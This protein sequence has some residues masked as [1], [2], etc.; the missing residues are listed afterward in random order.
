MKAFNQAKILKNFFKYYLKQ[1]KFQ[2]I[3]HEKWIVYKKNLQS[4]IEYTIK[5]IRKLSK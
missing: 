2:N 4:K 5:L 3:H 1:K